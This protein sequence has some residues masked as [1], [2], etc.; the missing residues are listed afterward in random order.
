V[1]KLIYNTQGTGISHRQISRLE[2]TQPG[3]GTYLGADMD[4]HPLGDEIMLLEGMDDLAE[5][6]LAGLGYVGSG[7][8]KS[9]AYDMNEFSLSSA[10][11]SVARRSGRDFDPHALGAGGASHPRGRKSGRD[12]NP[13]GLG[14]VGREV[15]RSTTARNA[16]PDRFI[17]PN[18]YPLGQAP[19][20]NPQAK[21][22]TFFQAAY[23]G[24]TESYEH[25]S[26]TPRPGSWLN[27]L[28]DAASD[29]RIAIGTADAAKALCLAGCG[30]ADMAAADRRRCRSACEGLHA[31]AMAT[32]N[33]ALP[34]GTTGPTSTA[35]A[36]LIEAKLRALE[37]GADQAQSGQIPD[38]G[39]ST[40]TMV[41]IGGAALLGV[42]LIVV[43]ARR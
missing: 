15:S 9:R 17:S 19:T 37:Q 2:N 18:F 14:R 24:N 16:R 30:I 43:L 6:Q 7:N 31:T 12:F 34:A 41:L 4:G 39:M 22:E 1:K 32:I 38:E 21:P 35:Q 36:E 10:S 8:Y 28:S 3:P 5:N 13:Y 27:G 42:G 20:W 25:W 29:R 26:Q 11:L 23:D 40:T 33:A